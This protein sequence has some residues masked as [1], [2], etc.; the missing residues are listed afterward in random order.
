MSE[1]KESTPAKATPAKLAPLKGGAHLTPLKTPSKDS[2]ERNL[3]ADDSLF[4]EAFVRKLTPR[5]V[6][7]CRLLGVL[8]EELV[9]R[10]YENFYEHGQK[11][12]TKTLQAID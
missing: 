1:Q 10:S 9:L 11:K 6:E 8:P 2:G 12:E 5:S 4:T 7:S 3:D